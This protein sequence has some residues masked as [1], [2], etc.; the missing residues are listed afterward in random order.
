VFAGV[1]PRV[2]SDGGVRKLFRLLRSLPRDAREARRA[3]KVLS[4][5]RRKAPAA[6]F[7]LDLYLANLHEGVGED[8]EA[9][10]LFLAAL[11][12]NPR[13]AGAWSDLGR[14]YYG[15]YRTGEAWQCWDTARR[16]CPGHPLLGEHDAREQGL[17]ES[18]PDFF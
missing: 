5:L 8:E 7:V 14:V 4:R 6:A 18:Y 1:V 11:G 10:R 12:E 2:K 3:N 15:R 17:R 16:L 13:I 9:E